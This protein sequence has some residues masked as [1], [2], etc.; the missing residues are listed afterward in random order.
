MN[1]AS[2]FLAIALTLTA[3]I[4]RAEVL[5][6]AAASLKEPLDQMAAAFDDVVVSYGGSGTLARQIGLGAPADIVL[7]ANVDWMDALE[8][9]GH[10]QPHSVRDFASN[11]LVIVGG[12][13][14]EP[15]SLTPDALNEALGLGRIAVGLTEAVPAGIYAKAALQ[16]SGLWDVAEDRLAEVD[17][18][19]SALA[20]VIRGQAPLGIVYRTDARISD[21]IT[22]VAV[23][24]ADSHPPIRYVGALTD[25]A[26]ESATT[27]LDYVLSDE[28]QSILAAS[29]FLPAL[30]VNQ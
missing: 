21:A 7:L 25:N 26:D 20:L 16:S 23:F 27:F 14:A 2:S 13:D 10:V 4:A 15:F 1:L 9:G 6:F 19:R 28:G 12:A 11:R 18:V 5:V 22:E 3:P 29:G 8:E 30:D 24:T 17:S